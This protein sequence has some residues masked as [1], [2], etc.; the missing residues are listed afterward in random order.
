MKL[1]RNITFAMKPSATHSIGHA[2]LLRGINVGGN[3]IVPMKALADI[4]ARAG[5]ENVRTYIQSGN[6]LFEARPGAADRIARAV[7]AE[8]EKRFGFAV[9]VLVRTADELRLISIN[10]PFF[11]K[12][13]PDDRLY[14]MFL[15]DTPDPALVQALDSNRS[16]QDKFAVRGRD[17]Y[18]S[19]PSGVARTKL[20]NAYFDS[21]LKTVSTMRNWRTTLKLLELMGG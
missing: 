17:I 21:K 6:V 3:N 15:A 18:L 9:P 8:I 12:G 1:Y 19:L 4:F 13:A 10:N 2:A 5:A 16:P 11:G 14:V 20:T 7:G